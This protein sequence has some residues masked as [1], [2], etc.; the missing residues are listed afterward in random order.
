MGFNFQISTPGL[1]SVGQHF[2]LRLW[3]DARAGT[4]EAGAGRQ[5]LTAA[6]E[7]NVSLPDGKIEAYQADQGMVQVHLGGQSAELVMPLRGRDIGPAR[8]EVAEIGSDGPPLGVSEDHEFA[9]HE[10]HLK[11]ITHL[12][13]HTDG[14]S[15]S[16]S[17][18]AQI[19]REMLHFWL[20]GTSV[21]GMDAWAARDSLRQMHRVFH[22]SARVR[23][24]AT[25][26][27]LT[28]AHATI[29]SQIGRASCRERVSSPV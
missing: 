19:T 20:R 10:I 5:R 2:P 12:L 21:A 24:D 14:L 8:I 11:G 4:R 16:S 9:Q 29:P 26:I 23:D 18:E 28:R 27:I 17:S 3:A 1:V 15:D 13:M 7:V 25:F 22:E 6:L